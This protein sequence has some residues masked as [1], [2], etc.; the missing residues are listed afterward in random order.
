MVR[1]K[2]KVVEVRRMMSSKKVSVDGRDMWTPCE[3]QTIRLNPV[4]SGSEENK[5]FWEATPSG[6]IELGVINEEAWKGFE[7][8]KEYYIDFTLAEK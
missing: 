5:K 4:S 8:D 6:A 3:M 2:F 1:A 7:L